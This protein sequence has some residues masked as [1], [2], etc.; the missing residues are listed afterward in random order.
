MEYIDMRLSSPLILLFCLLPLPA[1]SESLLHVYQLAEKNDPQLKAEAA[2]YQAALEAATL[3][4]SALL[5]Q[6]DAKANYT[7]STTE[8]QGV[9]SSDTSDDSVAYSLTLQQTLFNLSALNSYRVSKTATRQ[10]A[11]TFSADQQALII[12]TA[13]GYFNVLRALDQL[14]TSQTE[15]QALD[16][17]LQQTNQRYAVGLISINDVHQAQAAYDNALA[18]TLS[19]QA[20]L[21]IE[22]ESLS[23]LTGEHPETLA[24]LKDNFVAS[25][26]E[27]SS[28]QAWIDF[29]LQNNVALSLS[30]LNSESARLSHKATRAKRYPTLSGSLSYQRQEDPTGPGASTDTN[31]IS[32]DL[33]MP[34][35]TGGR[36]TA[37][38]RQAAQQQIEAEQLLNLTRRNTIQTTRTLFLSVMTD[39]AQI[40]ARQQAIVSQTSALEATQAG[41]EAGT[42]NIV[43]LVNAQ[44]NLF[45]SQRDYATALYDYIINSLRLKEVAGLLTIKDLEAL[46]MWLEKDKTLS[47]VIV[48]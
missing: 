8:G 24:P 14:R 6:I 18:N 43:D 17:Q 21:G 3:G 10:A 41:Y 30:Q 45:Q 34:I 12:R 20:S 38:A 25:A 48:P 1:L 16:T 7:D 5:P 19:A 37:E 36:H 15:K 23:T 33:A 26:P 47:T 44:R 2:A 39:I 22:L 9:T 46:D 31:A 32:L 35:Y 29:A 42:E 4:R 40:N 11:L 28:R 13:E 27:P